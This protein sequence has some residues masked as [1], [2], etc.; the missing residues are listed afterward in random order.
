MELLKKSQDEIVHMIVRDTIREWFDE[1]PLSWDHSFNEWNSIISDRLH[2]GDFINFPE[3]YE[4][5]DDLSVDLADK[6]NTLSREMARKA[7]KLMDEKI[8]EYNAGLTL[9]KENLFNPK[10]NDRENSL[11]GRQVDVEGLAENMVITAVNPDETVT[12]YSDFSNR[13]Y[14]VN[15]EDVRFK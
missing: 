12:V 5:S 9:L 2:E 13:N 11:I 15:M 8:R 7:E 10:T 6:I 3:S 1:G 4:N 14:R